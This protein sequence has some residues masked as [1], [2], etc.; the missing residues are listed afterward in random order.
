VQLWGRAES[1]TRGRYESGNKQFYELIRIYGGLEV[2]P[3]K[4]AYRVHP[5][6]GHP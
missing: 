4:S 5:V 2:R 3:T 6:Y 1:Q